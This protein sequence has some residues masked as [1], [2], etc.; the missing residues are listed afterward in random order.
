[1]DDEGLEEHIA[2]MNPH[3]DREAIRKLLES[4]YYEGWETTEDKEE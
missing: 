1:V 3:L 4:G 2:A